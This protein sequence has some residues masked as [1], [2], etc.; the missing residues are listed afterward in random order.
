MVTCNPHVQP[1]FDAPNQFPTIFLPTRQLH[2]RVGTPR[3]NLLVA[4]VAV[5]LAAPRYGNAKSAY[6][7]GFRPYAKT[8]WHTPRQS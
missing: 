3:S 8:T 7:G 2:Q 1:E 6:P 4:F 5:L